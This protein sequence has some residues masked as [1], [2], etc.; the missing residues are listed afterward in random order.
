MDTLDTHTHTHTYSHKVFVTCV[1]FCAGVRVPE[2]ETHFHTQLYNPLPGLVVGKL[3]FRNVD[4]V[5]S[6]NSPACQ[7]SCH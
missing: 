2:E 7:L 4:A 5:T 1:M 6:G 3:V